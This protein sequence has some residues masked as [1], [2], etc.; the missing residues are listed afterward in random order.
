[1]EEMQNFTMRLYRSFATLM[2]SFVIVC[3]LSSCSALRLGYSNGESVVYWWLDGY[4]DF[5]ADQ[6]PWV[7]NQL[8]QLFEWHRK[9]QLSTYAQ[10]LAQIQKQIQHGV[11]PADVASDYDAMKKRMLIVL[12]K[13]APPLADLALSLRPSQLVRLEKKFA[14]NNEKY[15]KEYLKGDLEQRQLHRY[16]AVLKQTEYWFG[17]LTAEQEKKIHAASDARPLDNELWLNERMRR[18]QEMLTLLRKIQAEK[19]SR[20]QATKMLR[21]YITNAVN[22]FSDEKQQAFFESSNQNT[23]KMIAAIVNLTTPAQKMHATKKIQQWIEDCR[24]L[25]MKDG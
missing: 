14:S 15:R 9:T 3:L 13:A 25:E 17:N 19:P 23:M 12:D 18:Q 2:V 20:D 10:L 5:E 21:D 8:D 4:F 6:K 7:K 22:H 1:M 24:T 11:T 16:K